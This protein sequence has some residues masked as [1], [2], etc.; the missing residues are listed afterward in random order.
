MDSDCSHKIG[1][2]SISDSDKD[3]GGGYVSRGGG[4]VSG[5]YTSSTNLLCLQSGTMMMETYHIPQHALLV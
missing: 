1:P 2:P 4:C 5:T 3:W